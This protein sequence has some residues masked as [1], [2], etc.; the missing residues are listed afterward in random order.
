MIKV[1]IDAANFLK[2]HFLFEAIPEQDISNLI[3]FLEIGEF[4]ARDI[5]YNPGDTADSIFFILKGNIDLQIYKRNQWQKYAGLEIGDF[6]GEECFTGLLRLD[7]AVAQTETLILKLPKERIESL[8][9]E[10]PILERLLQVTAESRKLARKNMY[11]WLSPEETVYMISRK[12]KYFLS[13]RLILPAFL[14][15]GFIL[16]FGIGIKNSNNNFLVIGGIGAFT[17]SIAALWLWIDWGNDYYAVTSKRVLWIE[18]V[19]LLYDSFQEAPLKNILSSSVQSIYSLRL[20]IDYGTVNVK[21]YTGEIPMPNI[22][23]PEMM[24]KMVDGLQRRTNELSKL[25]EN[26]EMEAEIRQRIGLSEENKP[27]Q[28][29]NQAILADRRVYSKQSS[30]LFLDYLGLRYEKGGNVTYRKHWF[31]LVKKIWMQSMILF[32]LLIV[33]YYL[34]ESEFINKTSLS[35]WLAGFISMVGFFLYHYIDWLNDIYVVTPDYIYDIERKPL[36]REDKKS[37]Q[38]ENILSLEHC[39]VGIFGLLLNYGNVSINVGTEKFTFY[40]VYNPSGVQSEIFTRMSA[41][42]KRRQ[43]LEAARDRDRV[44]DWIAIYHKQAEKK[45]ISTIQPARTLKSE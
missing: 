7:Q 26:D 23:A 27:Q 2:S 45:A 30:A 6:C 11:K 8:S 28:E 1:D 32:G 25:G 21:T 17:A 40:G 44:A 15:I 35:I 9:E 20:I 38:L 3:S 24:V 12:H 18:K 4:K 13:L 39:R 34:F 19:F 31:V 36:G 41:Q 16:L 33:L 14:L 5:L 37:A 29:T 22:R 43:E 10:Y 42:Q